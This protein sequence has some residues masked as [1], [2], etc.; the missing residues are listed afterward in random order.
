MPELTGNPLTIATSRYFI[1]DIETLWSELS[2]RVGSSIAR[3][4]TSEAYR[5]KYSDIFSEMI[6]NLEFL[7]GGRILR[8]AGRIKGS[9]FN[10]YVLPFGDSRE[11]IGK[12]FS[13]S[14]VLWGEGGG[15]GTNLSPLRPEG[16][17]IRGVGGVS[18]GPISF[19]KASDFIAETI[20]IG[21]QRRAAGLALMTVRHPDILKF[22]NAKLVD[23]LIP[24]YN[25][26]VGV[27]EEFLQSVESQSV[28]NLKFAQKIYNTVDAKELWDTV[29][30]NMLKS[31][32]PGLINWDNLRENN[33]Y[34]YAPVI[35]TN[36]CQPE[37]ATLRTPD[38]I[39]QFKDVNIGDK[40]WS[41]DG[42][43]KITNKQRSGVKNVYKYRTN[44]S[45]FCGTDT[46]KIISNNKKIEVDK[47]NSI[48]TL[49]CKA[50][51][52]DFLPNVVMDGILIGDGTK[53]KASNNLVYL[54]IGAEDY[55]YFDSEIT[56]LIIRHRPGLHDHAYKVKTSIKS[57]EL[58]K[59]FDRVVPDRYK[60]GNDQ[61]IKS[62]LRGL[63]TANGSVIKTAKRVTLKATSKQIVEDV[64]IMLSAVGIR[65][66]IT[67]NKPKKVK[68]DNGTY[69]CK[70]SYDINIT[71]DSDIFYHTVGFIQ[72]YKMEKLKEYLINKKIKKGKVTFDINSVE[73]ISTE[74][75]YNIT[76]DGKHHTYWTGGCNVS[77]CGEAI[78][79]PY[80]T[81]CLGSIVLPKFVGKGGNTNWI[82]MQATIKNSIRFL[83]DVIDCNNYILDII[84][85]KSFDSRRI[86]LGYMGLA[87]YL[88]AKKLRY[89]SPKALEEK[90]KL[91]KF[92]RNCVYESLVE[93]SAEKGA[94]PK[95]DS[96]A[97]SKAKFIRTLPPAL[98]MDIKKFGSRCVTGLSIAPTGTISLIAEV[99]SG[100]EP[101]FLKAYERKDQVSN[102]I[103]I[104]DLY[105]N[106]LN[107]KEE[108]IDEW[109]VDTS[110]LTP[111]DHLETQSII[112]KFV[113]GGVSKTINFQEG[114]SH[115]TLSSLLL[116]YIR[117]LKGV[118]I[119]VDG[120]R[121]GQVLNKISK[122]KI[123]K[124]LDDN[125]FN[126]DADV[127]TVKCSSGSCEI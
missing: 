46:H 105:S 81:C 39:K 21:G 113:D 3:A 67:K 16:A 107:N 8:N 122:E 106:A 119:Y 37:W 58:P 116:E 103:Y 88:F 47:A 11:E 70:K 61:L 30:T 23:K 115:E 35:T 66:Y 20:K 51:I 112:Q 65:S 80:E 24:H 55:D 6:F 72:K 78:L 52:V 44:A 83:D 96:T 36:P 33:S 97:Y 42:W 54:C 109:F 118:T 29:I 12:Y 41:E 45:I 34:F 121:E 13:D 108:N 117:D 111:E 74:E 110:D 101:L 77:N 120:S 15:V 94:F 76:V 10:C 25:I 31:A 53:H 2:N 4:E 28:W 19:L 68:F 69:L 85:T 59:T 60:Y 86:G 79:S 48:D 71:T 93:L 62:F 100:I 126:S 43:V 95:F 123:K 114:V 99:S 49:R 27:T 9:L 57:N 17:P 5:K 87:D 84:K 32:E 56:H 1:E 64:Q 104:H 26:S 92:V 50:K 18:S 73:Y 98:R 40:I 91:A 75:V 102:R 90:E 14:F 127:D 89:G 38:G 63:Y 125:K 82:K 22:I 124:H 7:P